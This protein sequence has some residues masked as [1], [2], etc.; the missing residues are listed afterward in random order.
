MGDHISRMKKTREISATVKG[1]NEHSVKVFQKTLGAQ[2]PQKP[3]DPA[4][5]QPT[6]TSDM[7]MKIMKALLGLS[8]AGRAY[9]EGLEEDK[10]KAFLELDADARTAEVTKHVEAEKAKAAEQEAADKAKAAGDPE[11]EK[12]KSEI[13][14]LKAEREVEKAAARDRELK[15]VAKSQYPG[16]VDAYETL[17]SVDGLTEEQRK[18]ILAGL[19]RQ[20]DMAKSMGTTF[21]DD[22]AGEGSAKVK[23]DAK[24]EELAKE[25]NISKQLAYSEVTQDP[26]NAALVREMRAETAG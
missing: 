2:Q 18:P 20:Q 5:T 24:V 21:G 26:A 3:G 12:L 14:T 22:D 11:V 7:D 6:E 8:E 25:K 10:L 9:A 17:K 19:Q 13:G 4:P 1:A 15:E 16:V 23:F